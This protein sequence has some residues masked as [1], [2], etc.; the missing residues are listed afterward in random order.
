M[1][2][3]RPHAHT[4]RIMC[5]GPRPA[6]LNAHTCKCLRPMQC[7]R[8]VLFQIMTPDQKA[9][10]G[11]LLLNHSQPCRSPCWHLTSSATK[12]SYS[13]APVCHCRESTWACASWPACSS[14]CSC[15]RSLSCCPAAHHLGARRSVKSACAASQSPAAILCSYS[16]AAPHRCSQCCNLVS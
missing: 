1:Q 13:S 9:L 8:L 15:K 11:G 2:A 16:S 5:Q 3:S 14:G 7:H 4:K 12:V 6:V 10:D